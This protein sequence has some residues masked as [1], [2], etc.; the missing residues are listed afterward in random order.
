[1][2]LVMSEWMMDGYP[3][4]FST[5]YVGM[6]IMRFYPKFGENKEYCTIRAA[7]TYGERYST[8]YP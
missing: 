3:H 8:M 7:E 2:G 6:D 4:T 1:M 5:D